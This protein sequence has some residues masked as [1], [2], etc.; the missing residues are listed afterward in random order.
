MLSKRFVSGRPVWEAPLSSQIHSA[1][2]ESKI[3]LTSRKLALTR[4]CF[5]Y[6]LLTGLGFILP[7]PFSSL[8]LSLPLH[9]S[10]SLTAHLNVTSQQ[11]QPCCYATQSSSWP[12]LVWCRWSLMITA[13]WLIS[14]VL[15]FTDPHISVSHPPPSSKPAESQLISSHSCGR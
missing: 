14:S 3:E 9:V 5:I 4:F 8:S 10:F 12:G 11:L 15:T 2:A 13:T 6:L 1:V 7:S